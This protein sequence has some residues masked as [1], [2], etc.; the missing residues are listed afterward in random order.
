MTMRDESGKGTLCWPGGQEGR[1]EP[2]GIILVSTFEFD[3]KNEIVKSM[4]GFAKQTSEFAK[5][6]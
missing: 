5:E 2:G 1:Q 3:N 4:F 6:T